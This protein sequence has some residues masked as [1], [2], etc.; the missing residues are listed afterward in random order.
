MY[1]GMALGSTREA[2]GGK[3]TGAVSNSSSLIHFTGFPSS[4]LYFLSFSSSCSVSGCE[5]T[6]KVKHPFSLLYFV[7]LFFFI[8]WTPDVRSRKH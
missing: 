2:G 5:K 8:P 6:S 4:L 1:Q 3:V 7:L